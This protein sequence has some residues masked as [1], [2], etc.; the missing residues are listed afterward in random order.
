MTMTAAV[1][2]KEELGIQ[3]NENDFFLSKICFRIHMGQIPQDMNFC[4]NVV[5]FFKVEPSCD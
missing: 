1:N 2:S 4:Q 5:L 3:E